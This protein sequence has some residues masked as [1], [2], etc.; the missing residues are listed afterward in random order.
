MYTSKE[1]AER[2]GISRDRFNSIVQ[3]NGIEPSGEKIKKINR[4]TVKIHTFTDE[5]IKQVY[6]ILHADASSEHSLFV[7]LP[8][9]ITGKIPKTD[10]APKIYKASDDIKST[11]YS[12]RFLEMSN[13][14]YK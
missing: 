6:A 1:A 2:I 11:F 7:P 13:A 5:A 8:A 14:T 4:Y 9:F 10:K 12:K 3:R